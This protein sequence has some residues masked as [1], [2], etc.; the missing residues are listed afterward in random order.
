M[1]EYRLFEHLPPHSTGGN[2]LIFDL[3]VKCNTQAIRKR[4]G[5]QAYSSPFD[6]MDSV[7]GLRDIARLLS[8]ERNDYFTDRDKWVIRNDYASRSNIVR[9]KVIYHT[10]FPGL[11]YPHFHAGWFSDVSQSDLT[12]WQ[13]DPDCSLDLVWNG[14]SSTFG[15]RLDRLKSLLRDDKQIS[16]LRIDEA[17]SI[18]RIYSQ[19]NTDLDIDYF[20]QKLAS[21]GLNSFRLVYIYGTNSQYNRTITSGEVINAIPIR[22]DDEYDRM[23]EIALAARTKDK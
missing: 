20:R 12:A 6:N 4:L 22:I 8:D 19:G 10:G 7:H 21:A 1:N 2:D 13:N 5:I 23:V 17:R 11:F 18:Q 3:G 15:R 9:A 16:F 14:F